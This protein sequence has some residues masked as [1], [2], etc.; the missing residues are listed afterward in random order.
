MQDFVKYLQAITIKFI[1]FHLKKGCSFYSSQI[2]LYF[3]H[4]TCYPFSFI[5]RSN[6]SQPYATTFLFRIKRHLSVP[7]TLRSHCT[8]Y[9]FPIIITFSFNSS[10]LRLPS[11]VSIATLRPSPNAIYLSFIL[12]PLLFI[13]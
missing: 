7:L 8:I 10:H 5:C 12:V 9:F 3:C 11:V 1:F 2:T 6:I 13:F 4:S